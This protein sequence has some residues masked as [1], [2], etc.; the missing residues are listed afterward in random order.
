MIDDF[1]I[2]TNIIDNYNNMNKIM[3]LLSGSTIFKSGKCTNIYD[4]KKNI[5][6][7]QREKIKNSN[8]EYLNFC[9]SFEYL[10][11]CNSFE[12]RFDF[13]SEKKCLFDHMTKN[14]TKNNVK[15][16]SKLVF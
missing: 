14:N 3:I 2:E 13:K 8:I 12:L 4:I 6:H 9:N 11:F 1:D 15:T 7:T 10:N 5:N 16:Q